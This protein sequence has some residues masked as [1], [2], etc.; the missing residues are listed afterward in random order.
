LVTGPDSITD[1]IKENSDRWRE[2]AAWAPDQ[3]AEEVKRDEIDILIDLAGH[4]G[5]NALLHLARKP[6]PVQVT[7]LGYPNTTGLNAI[8]WRL[9]D[10]HADPQGQDE[11]PMSERPYRLP[12]SFLLYRP[13]DD[14]P[15]ITPPPFLENGHVTFGS[16]NNL[17]KL[18]RACLRTW[19]E[20]LTAVP[21]SRLL[22]KAKVLRDAATR[23]RVGQTLSGWGLDMDRVDLVSYAPTLRAHMATYSKVD[24]ALDTFPYNGTTTT[25]EALQMGVPMVGCRGT[26]H[27]GRVGASIITNLGLAE[28]LLGK[29]P[30]DM[31]DKAI[32]LANDLSHL[33]TLRATLRDALLASPGRQ[34]MAFMADLETAYRDM[35]RQWVTGPPTHEWISTQI[36]PSKIEAEDAI[37]PEL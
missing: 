4:T 3:F 36:S 26:R 19:S 24:I 33:T 23:D 25:Y 21:D 15:D 16:F 29:D 28:S 32:S 34:T 20:I 37:T 27:S 18:S 22:L 11:D 1:L 10:I 6:A 7:Y 30:D 14:L 5:N 8:D 31:R 17:S 2:A 35:W 13:V 9:T 12:R